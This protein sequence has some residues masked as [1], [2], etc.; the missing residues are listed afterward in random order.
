MKS[1]LALF[2]AAAAGGLSPGQAIAQPTPQ[3]DA[4]ALARAI[5]SF[6]ARLLEPHG[7]R[8]N[9]CLSPTSAGLALLMAYAGA[10][11]ETAA[12]LARA[13]APAEWSPERIHA[14]AAVLG[15][16][17]QRHVDGFQMSSVQGFWAQLGHPLQPDFLT[18]LSR[19]YAVTARAVD[20]EK[21]HEAARRTI[22]TS[23]ARQTRGRIDQLLQPGDVTAA[24]RLILTN[25]LYLEARWLHEFAPEDTIDQEFTLDNGEKP[26]VKTMMVQARFL[27]LHHRGLVVVRL[28]YLGGDFALDLA[29]PGSTETLPNALGRLLTTSMEDWR[30]QLAR[31]LLIVT[32]PRFCIESRLSLR[33]RLEAIGVH[34]AFRPGADFS[35]ITGDPRGLVISDVV[36]ATWFAVAEKGTEAAAATALVAEAGAAI[37]ERRPRLVQFNRPFAFALRDLRTNLVLFAGNCADP[38]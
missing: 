19:N 25:T 10:R 37:E 14:A 21:S 9:V 24:T 33:A 30:R 3:Q 23:I 36:Q 20:F 28:P 16:G 8:H 22:N 35:A 13:L 7:C 2:V 18:L 34:R 32:L 26:R 4:R 38:R 6:G 29:L 11:G 5:G 15:G 12:E 1:T 31:E 27:A 17:M